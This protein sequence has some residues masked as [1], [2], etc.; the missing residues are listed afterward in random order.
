MQTLLKEERQQYILDKLH[1]DGKVV[2]VDLCEALNVSEDT[3]RRDLRELADA[4]MIQRVH[5][6]ALLR[7]PIV[8]SFTVRQ[9][10]QPEIKAALARAAAGLVQSGQMVML[11][12]G[13]TTLQLARSLP[14][15][16][17]AT[18]VTNS[19]SVM[20]ALADYPNVDV[21][22]LG[23]KLLKAEL[24]TSGAQTIEDLQRYRFDLC[25]LGV[26][27]LHPDIGISML[28]HEETYVLRAAINCS[29]DA[30]AIAPADRLDT[31]APYV[32]GS[33]Q[34]LTHLVTESTVP[35]SLLTPYQH[36]GITV[37]KAEGE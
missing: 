24:N 14:Y 32:V 18:I 17:Q 34:L 37:I 9:Q 21:I 22:G 7:S 11:F 3:I 6:G 13:T 8:P 36:L 12:G 5:G 33:L 26:C 1:R 16:L 19:P 31:A 28:Q 20:L 25:V 10:Q 2:A 23:G 35:D 29:A 30:V 15:D 4:G 27:S